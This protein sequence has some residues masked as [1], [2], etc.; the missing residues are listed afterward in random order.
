MF[1]LN[2]NLGNL[3]S[4]DASFYHYLDVIIRGR[5][6]RIGDNGSPFVYASYICQWMP[7]FDPV[8]FRI[9]AI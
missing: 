1:L 2:D 6:H 8:F 5:F 9:S 4:L 7:S 3:R